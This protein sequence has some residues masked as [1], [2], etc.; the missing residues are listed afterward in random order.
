LAGE[1][2][3]LPGQGEEDVV[4][5]G[6]VHRKSG[7]VDRCAVEPVKQRPQRADTAVARDLEG[8]RGIV[9]GR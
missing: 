8:E 5:I 9:S 6:C 3:G 2:V 7:D 4:E 1:G